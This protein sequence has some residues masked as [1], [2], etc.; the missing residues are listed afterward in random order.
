LKA[1]RASLRNLLAQPFQRCLRS[2]ESLTFDRSS[3]ALNF[4]HRMVLALRQSALDQTYLR[5]QNSVRAKFHLHDDCSN[6]G[7][8]VRQLINIRDPLWLGYVPGPTYGA[9]CP[10]DFAAL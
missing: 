2:G 4:N 1:A 6:A 10:A 5:R 7:D 8:S 9:I 3:T